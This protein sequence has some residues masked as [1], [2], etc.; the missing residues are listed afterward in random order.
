MTIA[1]HG[2]PLHGYGGAPGTRAGGGKTAARAAVIGGFQGT[3]D[4]EAAKRYG[5]A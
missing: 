1:A 4:L 2:R 5:S 3:S